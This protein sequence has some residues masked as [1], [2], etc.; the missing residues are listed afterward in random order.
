MSPS[1]DPSD[2][3]RNQYAFNITL[4][5]VAGQVGCLTLVIVLVALFAGLWLDA[6]FG[7]KPMLTISLTIASIP[8]TLVA[9][10]WVVRAATSR[11]QSTANKNNPK[12]QEEETNS[13]KYS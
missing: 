5:A 12:Q 4:A 3:N 1:S 10:F 13:G 7:T 8:S 9:M 6:R 11:L 2:K